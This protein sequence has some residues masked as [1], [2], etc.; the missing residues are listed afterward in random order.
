[1]SVTYGRGEPGAG[2]ENPWSPFRRAESLAGSTLLWL[3]VSGFPLR[4]AEK[5]WIL[6]FTSLFGENLSKNL[7]LRQE[8]F[9]NFDYIYPN[10]HSLFV[11]H[12]QE[13]FPICGILSSPSKP[14]YRPPGQEQIQEALESGDYSIFRTSKS[15]AYWLAR[16]KGRRQ[17]EVFLGYGAMVS[18]WLPPGGGAAAPEL[19]LHL[20]VFRNPLF[21]NLD[22]RAEIDFMNSLNDPFLKKSKQVFAP[23]LDSDPQY[24]G[25]LFAVPL[26]SAQDIFYARG[27]Q[28]EAWLGLFSAYLAE[29][30]PDQGILLWCRPE[31]DPMLKECL[32]A[33]REEK[34]K[35]PLVAET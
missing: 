23:G 3:P 25:M 8:N 19:P 24:G 4:T 9:L 13:F 14:L 17:A 31:I 18:L 5:E 1:M 22:L 12:A 7:N 33:L 15:V 20:K 21:A 32:E 6:R 2:R 28:R 35:Y 16:K 34:L 11:A 30:R 10:L 29:S 26:M 27:E